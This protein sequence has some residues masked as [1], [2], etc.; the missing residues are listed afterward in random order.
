[1]KKKIIGGIIAALIISTLLQVPNYL[2]YQIESALGNPKT[3]FYGMNMGIMLNDVGGGY[4]EE[5]NLDE[6]SNVSIDLTKYIDDKVDI[7]LYGRYVNSAD[8]LVVILN[9]K[10]I[11]NGQPQSTMSDFYA[12]DYIKKHFVVKLTESIQKGENK[13]L[14]STGEASES[15]DL[16]IK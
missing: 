1:M 4:D 14:V 8:P 15:Y 9:D 6:L 11:Y 10:V 12:S 2:R 13:L 7:F 3:Y 16:T 5:I